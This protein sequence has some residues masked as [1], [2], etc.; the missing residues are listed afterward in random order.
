[1]IT[2]IIII[3]YSFQPNAISRTSRMAEN[4]VHKQNSPFFTLYP[5]LIKLK[6]LYRTLYY[7]IFEFK[8]YKGIG[9]PFTY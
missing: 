3:S 2:I 8:T 9:T 5:S 6:L 7:F 4:L 1:M